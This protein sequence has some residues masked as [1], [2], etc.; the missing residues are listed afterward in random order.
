VRQCAGAL[1]AAACCAPL[2]AAEKPDPR[3]EL[4]HLELALAEAADRV[5][6]PS[7][8]PVLAAGSCRGYRIQGLGAVFVL[9]PRAL[10][11]QGGVLALRSDEA[12]PSPGVRAGPRPPSGRAR[13]ADPREQQMRLV[14]AQVEAFQREAERSREEAERALEQLEWQLRIKIAPPASPGPDRVVVSGIP[15]FPETL[16]APEAPSAPA[17]PPPP[18][19]GPAPAVAEA[20][21]PP[22]A[23]W[24]YWFQSEGEDD[25]RPAHQIVADVRLALTEALEAEGA[26]LVSLAPEELVV[27][28]VD[29]VAAPAFAAARRTDRTLVIRV[30]KKDLEERRAGK[31][32]GEELR[33]RI[34]C[35]EY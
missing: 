14:E 1:L 12:P 20:P 34:E 13:L 4:A 16:A 21:T 10:H 24:K 29:F 7:G 15:A 3:G 18:A 32:G 25:E 5:S 8:F 22:P 23:P 28:A 6:Q 27:T 11:T 33:K 35:A 2:Q 9:A 19:P 17:P 26:T 30:R 31:I